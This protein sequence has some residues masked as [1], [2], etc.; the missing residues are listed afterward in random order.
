M[1]ALKKWFPLISLI[2][3]V[4]ALVMIFLPCVEMASETWNGLKVAFGDKDGIVPMKFSI[5]TTL[6]YVLAI[7]GG[8]LAFLG[9]KKGNNV[10][11][12]AA[13]ACFAVAA[14]FFFMA[15]NFIQFKYGSS[16]E[17]KEAR[18]LFDPAIGSILG[19]IFSLVGAASV[20]CDAFVKE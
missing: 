10:M 6:T 16:S 1:K 9:A 3:G 13:I 4:A 5:C 12:Y 14:I 11:K 7:A 20:A 8:A 2:C 18:K 19:G 17:A 15:P